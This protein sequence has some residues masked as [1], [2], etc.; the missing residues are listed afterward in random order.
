VERRDRLGK[1]GE[2]KG[3]ETPQ[4]KFLATPLVSTL[5]RVADTVDYMPMC[6]LG[7]IT[8]KSCVHA[9]KMRQI[10]NFTQLLHV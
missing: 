10:H 1:G 3:D 5:N 4:L 7:P 6:R 8:N 2:G 9:S